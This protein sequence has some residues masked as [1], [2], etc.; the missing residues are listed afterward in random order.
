MGPALAVPDALTSFG[1]G[2]GEV[3]DG[4]SCPG[5]PENGISTS[6]G[7]RFFDN[8]M[9]IAPRGFEFPR[10]V[11]QFGTARSSGDS[12][13]MPNGLSF[14]WD[15]FSGNT[16]NCWYGNTGPNGNSGPGAG[17]PP[18]LLPSDCATS[19]GNGDVFKEAILVDCSEGP[20]EDTGPTDCP[21]WQTPPRPGSAEARDERQ[22]T[23]SAG[24]RFESS[25]EADALRERI[26][27]LTAEPPSGD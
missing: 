17:A 4:I 26:D 25:D 18:D 2:E 14:W 10:A 21:W 15:E 24:R 8:R 19:V 22:E 27:A 13:V 1:G 11:D 16:G 20:D 5:A 9:G 23:A 6:C 12:R 3:Y 7:N